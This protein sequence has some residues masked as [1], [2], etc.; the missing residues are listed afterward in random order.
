[1]RMSMTCL[2]SCLGLVL[3]ANAASATT[4]NDVMIP[5]LPEVKPLDSRSKQRAEDATDKAREAFAKQ[6]FPEA[7]AAADELFELSPN[8]STAILRAIIL[9]KLGQHRNA[10]ESYIIAANLDPTLDERARIRDGIKA[11][12]PQ[13]TPKLGS[14]KIEV[15]PKDARVFADGLDIGRLRVIGLS[16]G[17]H[18]IRVEA[19]NY[20][21][22]SRK[23]TVAAGEEAE[24]R[25]V[26]EEIAGPKQLDPVEEPGQRSYVA[27]IAFMVTGGA[28]LATGIGLNVWAAGRADDATELQNAPPGGESSTELRTRETAYNSATD[29]AELGAT[30]AYVS[31]AVGAAL[32]GTGVV[33]LLI[34]GDPEGKRSVAPALVPGG[35]GL[36]LS[37]TF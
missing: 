8:A 37:G 3:L 2:A 16:E 14:L 32:A 36:Q 10:F 7:L 35:A 20:L 27:P 34:D 13:A 25:F 19:A 22:K 26:L 33:L 11:H 18:E 28:L 17:E 31:Y 12:G 1:M 4:G 15:L 9:D 30:L 5:T 29:D 23:I 21:S 6:L 24:V